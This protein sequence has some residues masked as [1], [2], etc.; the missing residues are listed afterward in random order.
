MPKNEKPHYSSGEKHTTYSRK[1]PIIS[2]S[3]RGRGSV[4]DIT[5]NMHNVKERY[6]YAEIGMLFL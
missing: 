2:F 5:V 3:M 1:Q 4:D 6:N